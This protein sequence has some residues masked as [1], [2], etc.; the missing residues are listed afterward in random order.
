MVFTKYGIHIRYVAN[1]AKTGAPIFRTNTSQQ[2]MNERTHIYLL[3]LEYG[4]K[5]IGKTVD[6][7]KRMNQHFYGYGSEVTK[8]FRPISYEILDS[9]YGY[10]A[11]DLE[12]NYTREFINIYGYENVRGGK[13]VNSKTLI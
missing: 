1:Y 10:F 6:I 5:Y 7:N 3:H 13:Y 8:K 11:D 12:N 4:K 9:C 2:N